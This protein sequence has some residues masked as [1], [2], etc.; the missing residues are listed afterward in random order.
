M[1]HKLGWTEDR[2]WLLEW[3]DRAHL[4]QLATEDLPWMGLNNLPDAVAMQHLRE[5]ARWKHLTFVQYYLNGAD[6]VVRY[7]K[8][9]WAS[10]TE[11]YFTVGRPGWTDK[12]IDGARACGV[13]NTPY[14]YIAPDL[15]DVS[16]TE[17]RASL[18][19]GDSA[20][21]RTGAIHW[22]I[23]VFFCPTTQLML[24]LG[25]SLGLV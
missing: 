3:Y 5:E 7:E 16:A 19:C 6:D 17:V 2:S 11:R 9:T 22:S 20:P 4:V 13:W 24:L 21:G 12:V 18:R 10:E 8:W 25:G 23:S 14:F 15:P 1:W